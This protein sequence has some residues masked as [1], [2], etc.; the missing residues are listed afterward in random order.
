MEYPYLNQYLKENFE[1]LILDNL[2]DIPYDKYYVLILSQED[3]LQYDLAAFNLYNGYQEWEIYYSFTFNFKINDTIINY[4]VGGP[5]SYLIGSWLVYAPRIFAGEKIQEYF[6]TCACG[7]PGCE[8]ETWT[9]HETPDY[10]FWSAFNYFQHE[11]DANGKTL[12]YLFL[13][14]PSLFINAWLTIWTELYEDLENKLSQIPENT[15]VF[16]KNYHQ[17]LVLNDECPRYKKEVESFIKKLLERL[18][19][20]K[21]LFSKK[22]QEY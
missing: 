9:I 14:K 16:D 17:N 18:S 13:I 5:I 1:T 21:D 11:K 6:I 4:K 20:L 3:E 10:I 8:G 2:Y 15:L 22:L 19:E 12:G 7:D